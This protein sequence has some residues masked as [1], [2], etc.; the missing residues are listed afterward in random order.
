MVRARGSARRV[1]L[2]ISG[3]QRHSGPTRQRRTGVLAGWVGF[4]GRAG[5]ASGSGP[6]RKFDFFRMDFLSH[7]EVERNLGKI[8]R[9]L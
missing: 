1:G 6:R 8:I 5:M 9:D 2:G 7:T 3:P 4:M